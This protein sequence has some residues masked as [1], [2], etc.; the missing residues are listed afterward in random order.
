[1][2]QGVNPQGDEVEE[3]SAALAQVNRAGPGCLDEG[4]PG[5][6]TLRWMRR[7]GPMLEG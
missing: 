1:M 5:R 4:H 2:P 7:P 3:D 6:L